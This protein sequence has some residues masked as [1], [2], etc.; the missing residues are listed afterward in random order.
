MDDPILR[1]GAYEAYVQ[2]NRDIRNEKLVR[3]A[4]QRAQEASFCSLNVSPRSRHY[5]QVQYWDTRVQDTLKIEI[6]VYP[7]V[8]NFV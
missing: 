6:R 1:L 3:L 7:V 4:K 2:S 8:L 5:K